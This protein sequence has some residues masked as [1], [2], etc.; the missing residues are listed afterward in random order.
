MINFDIHADHVNG[1]FF[2]FLDEYSYMTIQLFL[3]V[4]DVQYNNTDAYWRIFPMYERDQQ[5][6]QE[7]LTYINK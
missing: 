3:S 4:F 2:H 7:L 5:I 6:M 1:I